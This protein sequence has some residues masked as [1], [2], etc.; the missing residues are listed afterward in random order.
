MELLRRAIW[1]IGL[2]FFV[3]W[4]TS[5]FLSVVGKHLLNWPQDWV[6]MAQALMWAG[7][8][9]GNACMI[10]CYRINPKDN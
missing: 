7:L 4:I 8:L 9:G 5:G 2:V 6:S 3:V 1:W 10:Y